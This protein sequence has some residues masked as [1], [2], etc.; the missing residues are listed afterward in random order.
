M[1]EDPSQQTIENYGMLGLD[2]MPVPSVTKQVVRGAKE[3]VP[4]AKQLVKEAEAANYAGMKADAN[5]ARKALT[6][7]KTR[8]KV[9]DVEINNPNLNYRQVGSGTAKDFI[10]TGNQFGKIKIS[11][12]DDPDL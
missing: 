11:P 9:G 12:T 6:S 8:I 7:G 1:L 5:A 2:F 4:A 10:E 3:V